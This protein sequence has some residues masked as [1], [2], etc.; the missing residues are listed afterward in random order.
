MKPADLSC[1]LECYWS[2]IGEYLTT[3]Q[4]S[5]LWMEKSSNVQTLSDFLNTPFLTCSRGH[6]VYVSGLVEF[7]V[8]ITLRGLRF[9]MAITMPFSIMR[10]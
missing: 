10:R 4:I 2:Y 9:M 3:L 8:N 6:D 1:R 7:L 5:V